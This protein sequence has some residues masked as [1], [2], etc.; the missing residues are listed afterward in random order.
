VVKGFEVQL[1]I[2][3]TVKEPGQLTVIV[4][5]AG[6]AQVKAVL[7]CTEEDVRK[8]FDVNFM[9]VWNRLQSR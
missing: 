8:M 4:A 1:M 6:I 2:D 9:G 3:Q 5:N 7:E